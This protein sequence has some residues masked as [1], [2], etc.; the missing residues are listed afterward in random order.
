MVNQQY[1][2]EQ[3]SYYR[4]KNHLTLAQ[5]AEQ[6]HITSQAVSKWERGECLPGTSILFE[7]ANVLETTIDN[8]LNG[9]NI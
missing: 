4:K 5:V 3:I 8:L 9:G 6:L 2:A 1:V 7:L